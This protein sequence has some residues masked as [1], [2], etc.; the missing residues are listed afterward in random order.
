MRFLDVDL[1]SAVVGR[2]W[3]AEP[4]LVLASLLSDRYRIKCML[5]KGSCSFRA[6][7]S[8][9]LELVHIVDAATDLVNRKVGSV[10]YVTVSE[11]S[12]VHGEFVVKLSSRRV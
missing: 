10:M 4:A 12:D 6:K 5:G 7:S 3:P 2:L 11:L 9:M 8:S 1:S